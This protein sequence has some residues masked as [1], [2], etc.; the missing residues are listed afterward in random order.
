MFSY[1][2]LSVCHQLLRSRLRPTSQSCR[3]TKKIINRYQNLCGNPDPLTRSS[4]PQNVYKQTSTRHTCTLL[5]KFWNC[6][7][8]RTKHSSTC[9]MR[10]RKRV[11]QCPT[12][13]TRQRVIF[14]IFVYFS[15]RYTIFEASK[16]FSLL[17]IRKKCSSGTSC[18]FHTFIIINFLSVLFVVLKVF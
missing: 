7:A 5:E 4:I 10:S 15:L 12:K 1:H 18:G 6:T 8:C 14:T 17:E 13:Q 3:L 16:T 9:W 11:N 2:F